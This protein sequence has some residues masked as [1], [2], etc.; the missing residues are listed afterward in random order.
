MLESLAHEDFTR[1]VGVGPG[2]ATGWI[3]QVGTFGLHGTYQVRGGQLKSLGS[4]ISTTWPMWGS[5]VDLQSCLTLFAFARD[6][7]SATSC[8]RA[9]AKL[10]VPASHLEIISSTLALTLMPST[11]RIAPARS[12]SVCSLDIGCGDL[13]GVV[14][15]LRKVLAL[16][17]VTTKFGV[18]QH[19]QSVAQF[20]VC[21]KILPLNDGS[22][23][24]LCDTCPA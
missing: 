8:A 20:S 12:A 18:T 3:C 13:R 11:R 10:S 2:Q 9:S 16:Q 17:C 14:M 22:S 24:G 1:D 4:D 21:V 19:F 5:P 15:L 6:F 23:L 7:A